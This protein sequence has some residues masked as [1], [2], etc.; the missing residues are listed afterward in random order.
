MSASEKEKFLSRASM[1][2]LLAALAEA[3]NI[4]DI[5]IAAGLLLESLKSQNGPA[6][7]Q[8]TPKA[9]KQI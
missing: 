2:N 1:K 5:N 7:G 4:T 8:E 3:R 9:T 6:Q